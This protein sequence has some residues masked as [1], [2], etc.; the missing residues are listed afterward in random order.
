MEARLSPKTRKASIISAFILGLAF[1]AGWTPCIGP[2]LAGIL[3]VSANSSSNIAGASALLFVYSLGLGIPFIITALF[4]DKAV[5]FFSFFK[6]HGKAV[7]VFS[8]L[9]LIILGIVIALNRMDFISA[10]FSRLIQV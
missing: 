7:E 8:G 6:R 3:T 9:F 10:W 4:T 5:S 1:G 2:V